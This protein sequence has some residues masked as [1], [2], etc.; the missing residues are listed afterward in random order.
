M[1]MKKVAYN[2]TF[3]FYLIVIKFYLFQKVINIYKDKNFSE[4]FLFTRTYTFLS[5]T[6]M[7]NIYISFRK[8]LVLNFLPNFIKC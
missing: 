3:Y 7:L 2:F 4:L 5:R 6:Y 1:I 8:F